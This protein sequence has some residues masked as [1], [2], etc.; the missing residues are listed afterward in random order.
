[1][2]TIYHNLSIISCTPFA[3]NRV[4]ADTKKTQIMVKPI[5]S[6]FHTES[7]ISLNFSVKNNSLMFE[8]YKTIIYL[9]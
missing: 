4:K 3:R 1:M 6:S 2:L 9:K 5:Q 7:K 8:T